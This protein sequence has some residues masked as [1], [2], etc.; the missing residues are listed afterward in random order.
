MHDHSPPTPP[1]Q[2]QQEEP[3]APADPAETPQPATPPLPEDALIILAVRGVVLFP[4]V[5]VPVTVG[6]PRSLAAV[7]EAERSERPLGVLLQRDVDVE[8][9]TPEHL[10]RVGTM[11]AILRY[12]TAPD[13][14]HHVIC[15][16]EQRFRVVEF[17]EGYPFFAARVELFE[18][19]EKT[20]K[21]IEALT[22]HVQQ[23]ALEALRLLPHEPP[24]L[25]SAVGSM[26]S[27]ASLTDLV[28]SFMDLKPQEK[29]AI[30]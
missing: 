1:T 15:Q 26:T 8:D 18:E 17:L 9:P 29:Q 4:G 20:G 21:A 13:G 7:Q 19:I 3:A 14:T 23:Q 28:G 30:L 6:R 10:H 16:G 5:V 24:D 27:A 11:C 22:H 12:L 25:V 2:P